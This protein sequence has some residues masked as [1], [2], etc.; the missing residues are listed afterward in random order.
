VARVTPDIEEQQLAMI[1]SADMPDLGD[2]RERLCRCHA[3]RVAGPRVVGQA[4]LI[5]RW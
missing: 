5:H 1:G 2:I 4:R 3:V